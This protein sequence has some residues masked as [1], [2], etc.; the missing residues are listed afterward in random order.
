[1]DHYII[2]EIPDEIVEKYG[3]NRSTITTLSEGRIKIESK[4]TR[5]TPF[6]RYEIFEMDGKLY[7][8]IPRK[9]MMGG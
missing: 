2:E 8:R 3:L 4:P 7:V 9:D 1:M 5:I 6:T